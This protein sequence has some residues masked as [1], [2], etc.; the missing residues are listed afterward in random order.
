MQK[1][2][3][4][5]SAEIKTMRVLCTTQFS[6]T[7]QAVMPDISYS[8]QKTNR[9][10]DDKMPVIATS[11]ANGFISIYIYGNIIMGVEKGVI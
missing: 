9:L 4:K 5:R 6:E 10:S 3:P 8:K 7:R 2:G 11:A 1:P